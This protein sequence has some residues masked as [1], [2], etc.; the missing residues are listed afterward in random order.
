MTEKT[1]SAFLFLYSLIFTNGTLLFF[2][3]FINPLIFQNSSRIF[4]FH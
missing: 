4:I 2:V 3:E 1:S